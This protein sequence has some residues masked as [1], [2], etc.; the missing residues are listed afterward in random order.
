MFY[1]LKKKNVLKH[2][3]LS[4]HKIAQEEHEMNSTI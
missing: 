4:A 2:I 1:P 3:A